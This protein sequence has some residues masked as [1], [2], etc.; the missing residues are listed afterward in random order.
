MVLHRE[1]V[2][3]AAEAIV[4]RDGPDAL[5]MS[6]LAHVLGLRTPSLYNHV[7]S[8]D[9]LRGEI[10][11][12]AM[13][14]LGSRFRHTAMGKVGVPG[15]RALARTLREFAVVYPGRYNL[16]M[17]AP[18][19]KEAFNAA[20]ADATAALGAIISS[21]GINT[22][23]PEAQLAVFAA[24]HGFIALENSGLIDDSFDVERIFELVLDMV[25]DQVNSLVPPDMRAV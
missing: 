5:T 7:A 1:D 25:V 6:A 18:Y 12:R 22:L 20:S 21:F 23:A 3:S 14:D 4:D 19:D 15:L 16:A 13:A 17:R 8:L 2:L 10:Q 11:N 9:A 24:L